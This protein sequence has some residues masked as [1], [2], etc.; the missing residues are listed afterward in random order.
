MLSQKIFRLMS[1]IALF[2]I[3][4]ASLAPSISHALSNPNSPQAFLQQ[5][6]GVGGQKLYIQVVTT[7]GQQLEAALD[8]KPGSQ[9]KT[10]NL[11][12]NHCPF[13]NSG[14]ANVVIPSYNPA[15]EL[16]LIQQEKTQQFDDQI[17][18]IPTTVQ[19]AHLTRGPPSIT[20]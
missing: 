14:V 15:F 17:T 12:M 2:A 18:A 16:Y 19:T 1:K 10:I 11:H 20:L 9:P 5:I 4:F 8:T 3:V 6:C 7:Q 13:C